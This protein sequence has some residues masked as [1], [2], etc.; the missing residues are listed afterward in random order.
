MRYQTNFSISNG[1]H[2][3]VAQLPVKQSGLKVSILC[4]LLYAKWELQKE[5]GAFLITSA[6][7]GTIEATEAGG[8]E[9]CFP[10]PCIFKINWGD[11]IISYKYKDG[12]IS[13]TTKDFSRDMPYISNSEN[14]SGVGILCCLRLESKS[15]GYP[16]F[17]SQ[18]FKDKIDAQSTATLPSETRSNERSALM[19]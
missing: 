4:D 12:V 9:R 19:R 16:A 7:V 2:A 10:L 6:S 13:D 14:T 11:K 1:V 15:L 8:H 18:Q 5:Y 17:F 3:S